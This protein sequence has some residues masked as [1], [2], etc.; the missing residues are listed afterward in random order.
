[1]A[2]ATSVLEFWFGNNPDDPKTVGERL[3]KWF[4]RNDAFDAEVKRTLGDAAEQAARGELDGW[5]Q[6]SPRER[7]ALVLLL[8]QVPRNLH[9]GDKRAFATD[10]KAQK[11]VTEGLSKGDEVSLSFLERAFFYMPLEHSERLEH[12]RWSVQRFE[13]LYGDA[14]RR[15]E[16]DDPLVPRLRA[17]P[18]LRDRQV[19]PVRPPERGARAADDPA[20][21]RLPGQ[22][23]GRL[24]GAIPARALSTRGGFSAAAAGG[25]RSPMRS[26]GLARFAWGVLAFNILVILWGGYVRASKSGAGCGDHWP[27]CQ[28]ELVPRAASLE[29]VIEFTHRITSGLALVSVFALAFWV[30]RRFGKGEPAR[31]AA[32]ASVFFMLMEAAV[33]AGLVL[34]RYVAH[35]TRLDRGYWMCAHLVNTFLL[36]AAL[37]LTAH[38][39][40][41]GGALKISPRTVLGGSF[42]ATAIAVC[43]VGMSG[44]I[45]A[46][47]DTLFP[48]SS[49]AEGIAQDASP[50][51]HLF[52]RMRVFHP[53][54]A[55]FA[56]V[57]LFFFAHTART[58]RPEPTVRRWSYTLGGLVLLQIGVGMVNLALLA[59][60]AMQM[61]HLA[62]ADLVW[63]A[64]IVLGA[65]V[66]TAGE[67]SAL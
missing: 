58:L 19:R 22:A 17:P 50:T 38:R 13:K 55:V 24:L 54:L 39:A 10:D 2:N 36:L 3:S 56:A 35:D 1:M 15:A 11:V 51:A 33:G 21:G 49:L 41:G 48:V 67:P 52:L 16:G 32:V 12:Q 40:G 30:F 63:I 4:T 26:S 62:I 42:L 5:A 18:P 28:G 27:T 45:A 64:F 47:G 23:P 6:S 8:D 60:I 46:L 31:R 66:L 61:V 59:P 34:L 37:A 53:V 65:H 29:T 43:I 25:R 14:P 44:G 57:M 9:R 20:R 7:L